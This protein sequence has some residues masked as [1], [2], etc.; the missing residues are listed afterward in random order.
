MLDQPKF[1][2][3]VIYVLIVAIALGVQCYF[4]NYL[5]D[6]LFFIVYIISNNLK[7]KNYKIKNDGEYTK[8]DEKKW[9]KDDNDR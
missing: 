9:V 8:N 5:K 1:V 4:V 3:I 7:I 6:F 2:I